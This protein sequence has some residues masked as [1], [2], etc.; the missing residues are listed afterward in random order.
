[1]RVRRIKRYSVIGWS[2][3]V[4][5]GV[6]DFWSLAEHIRPVCTARDPNRSINRLECQHMWNGCDSQQ[7]GRPLLNSNSYLHH[8]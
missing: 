5:E 8:R 2:S 7:H 4:N 3:S 1:M 6:R